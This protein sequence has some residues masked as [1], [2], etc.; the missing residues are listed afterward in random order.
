MEIPLQL[1]SGFFQHSFGLTLVLLLDGVDV[2]HLEV[3]SLDQVP[4]ELVEGQFGLLDVV[5]NDLEL[6]VLVKP[7]LLQV[8][9]LPLGSEP[10]VVDFGVDDTH[11]EAFDDRL[12][13]PF[14]VK[15]ESPVATLNLLPPLRMECQK[16]NGSQ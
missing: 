1:L 2:G 9:V 4:G 3:E 6:V 10:S 14:V 12:V 15:G 11:S 5:A 7:E 13:K 8:F 16:G